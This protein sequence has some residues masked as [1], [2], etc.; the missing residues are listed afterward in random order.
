MAVAAAGVAA[1]S[2]EVSEWMKFL[3]CIVKISW[4]YLQNCY[5]FKTLNFEC[6]IMVNQGVNGIVNVYPVK[7]L[8][9]T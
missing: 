1:K 5:G 2:T 3:K 4:P 8:N 7:S 6:F 9:V